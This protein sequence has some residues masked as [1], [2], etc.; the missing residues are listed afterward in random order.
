LRLSIRN[1]MINPFKHVAKVLG[2]NW[3]E[4][5]QSDCAPAQA[6]FAVAVASPVIVTYSLLSAL[7]KKSE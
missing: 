7:F 5:G 3:T 1:P 6:K 2:Q 4:A